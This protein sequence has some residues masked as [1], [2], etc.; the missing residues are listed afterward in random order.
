[1]LPKPFDGLEVQLDC[2]LGVKRAGAVA[3][4]RREAH[5]GIGPLEVFTEFRDV[6]NVSANERNELAILL[7]VQEHVVHTN[8]MAHLDESIDDR[9]ANIAAPARHENSLH[10]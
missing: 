3:N 6:A 9:P 8:V 10:G 2:D 5:H 7:F 1:M 4:E